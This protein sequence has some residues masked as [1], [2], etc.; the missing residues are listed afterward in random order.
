MAMAVSIRLGL[1]A[2]G[3][4]LVAPAPVHAAAAASPSAHDKF[5]KLNPSADA[6][7]LLTWIV[8]SGD[9]LELPFV[10]VDKVRARV[11]AFGRGGTLMGSSPGLRPGLAG[12]STAAIWSSVTVIGS[13]RSAAPLF[14]TT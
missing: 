14:V 12:Q 5:D 7:R 9:N 10:I 11:F 2:A 3:L 13:V 4:A 8:A 6:S 1:A